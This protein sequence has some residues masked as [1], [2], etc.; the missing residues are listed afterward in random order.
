MAELIR[1]RNGRVIAGVC[2]AIA[3]RFDMSVAVIRALM[4]ISVLFFGLSIW[5]YL[6]LWLVIPLDR[7]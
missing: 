3:N 1:P 4:V 6:I 2:V 7:R 5:L